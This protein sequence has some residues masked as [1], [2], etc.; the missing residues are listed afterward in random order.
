MEMKHQTNL[1]L[2]QTEV[3]DLLF[4]PDTCISGWRPSSLNYMKEKLQH[5]QRQSKLTALSLDS[6]VMF[7]TS[8]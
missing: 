6:T 7:H 2:H 1:L 3:S 4:V 8:I 5:S